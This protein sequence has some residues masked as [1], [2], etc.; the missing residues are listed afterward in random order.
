MKLDTL[1]NMKAALQVYEQL[2]FVKTET[3][4][5]NPLEGAIWMELDLL[6]YGGE[7]A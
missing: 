2:G 7:Q 1:E 3:Y 5:H 4:I 6:A